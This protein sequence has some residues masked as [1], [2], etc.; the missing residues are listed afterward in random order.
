[1][2]YVGRPANMVGRNERVAW[3]ITNN[4]CSQRDLYQ[5][6]TDAAHPGCFEFDGRW[7]PA[8]EVRETIRVKGAAPAE[9]TIRFSRNGPIV[10]EILPPPGN[11]TGPVSLKWLGAY[12]GGWLTAMLATNR[13]GDVEAFRQALRPWH[14]P[15]FNLVIADVEGHIAL[16]S[17]GRIPLRNTPQRAYRAGWDP[18]QQWI[19]L[20]PFEAM[21]H[22][23][24]PARGWMLSANHRLAANDYPYPLYGCWI[25]G[26]RGQRIRQ[27]IEAGL[28]KSELTVDDFGRMQMDTMSLRA[29]ECVPALIKALAG[30]SDPRARQAVER[31]QQWDYRVEPEGVAPTLFNVFH[32]FWSKAVVQARFEGAAAEL[33]TR[34]A[35]VISGR[36]L[37]ADPNGWFAAGQ[38]EPA[39]QRAFVQALDSLTQRFGPNMDDWRW[40]RLH[41][42][43]LKHVLAGRGELGSLL[44]HGGGAVSG[45]MVTVCNTGSGPDW[46]ATT[47]AGYRMIADLSTNGLWAIDAQ[48][49]SGLPGTPHYADQLDL[50]RSGKYHYLSLDRRG[51][52]RDNR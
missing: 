2:A 17:A 38:R 14:V 28:G 31:L 5:E 9:R 35:E 15:T 21:P 51:E 36:L 41:E 11:E 27:M 50:W 8:R 43:P 6:R 20:L 1:M 45:D 18:Q 13:A 37:A 39:I 3:G 19:G 40:G 22:A 30:V 48:S 16:Q 46:L 25:S 32:T 34:Q 24:D 47:G 4:I 29:A 49:E 10:D 26:Y 23:V 12:Q 52:R 44:N 42:L 7:E 33:I